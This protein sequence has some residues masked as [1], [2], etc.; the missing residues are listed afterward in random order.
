MGKVRDRVDDS[1]VVTGPLAKA[2]IIKPGQDHDAG[3]V[4]AGQIDGEG[5]IGPPGP[6]HRPHGEAAQQTYQ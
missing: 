3:R 1:R 2:R 5:G 6:C 4:G